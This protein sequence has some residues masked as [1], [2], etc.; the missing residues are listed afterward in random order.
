MAYSDAIR[1]AAREAQGDMPKEDGLSQRVMSFD[2]EIERV[3][4][5]D[6]EGHPLLGIAVR[7]DGDG[8]HRRALSA[9]C[10]AAN[11]CFHDTHP[12]WAPG[13]QHDYTLDE[14]TDAQFPSGGA[15]SG[16]VHYVLTSARW[17]VPVRVDITAA[18][19]S[20]F[21]DRL[22][23]A[24][25]FWVKHANGAQGLRISKRQLRFM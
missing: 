17:G 7:G 14:Y 16:R 15:L 13:V 8:G 24:L 1:K 23:N 12:R 9:R 2:A 22:E 6:A 4:L 21:Y 25:G 3:S 11:I 10:P 19:L 5:L 20:H 18:D